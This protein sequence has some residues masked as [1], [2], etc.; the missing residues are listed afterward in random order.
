MKRLALLLLS[1]GLATAA[2]AEETATTPPAA[3]PSATPAEAPRA[4][5]GATYVEKQTVLE[6]QGSLSLVGNSPFVTLL[7]VDRDG[8]KMVLTGAFEKE[9]RHLSGLTLWIKGQP[10]G[11]DGAYAKLEV[12]DYE[13]LDCGDGSK[14]YLGILTIISGKLVLTIKDAGPGIE[15]KANRKVLETLKAQAGTKAWV[16]GELKEGALKVRRYKVLTAE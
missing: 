11:M 14:P 12:T 2:L 16:A 7:F 4:K 15:L 8:A 6:F 5:T 1:A 10:R 13:I 3:A 9:L